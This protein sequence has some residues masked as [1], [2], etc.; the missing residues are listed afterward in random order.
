MKGM[1]ICADIILDT[2]KAVCNRW[3]I[4]DFIVFSKTP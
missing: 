2:L 1:V 3:K 4:T